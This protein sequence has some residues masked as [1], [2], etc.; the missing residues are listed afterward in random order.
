MKPQTGAFLIAADRALSDARVVFTANLP[1][2]A[3]RLAYYAE[4]HSAQALIFERTGKIAKTHKGVGNQFHLLAQSETS[5]PPTLAA[6][7][8]N[9]YKFKETAD[10][11][12]IQAT[13]ITAAQATD[14]I[15]TAERFVAAIRQAL[16]APSAAP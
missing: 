4:F 10:Y 7:L 6:D 3:A 9:A 13:P 15:A 11:D 2:Q 12:T 5:L 1:H 14:A 16:A 8:S